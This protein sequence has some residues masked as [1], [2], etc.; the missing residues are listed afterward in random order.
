MKKLFV[1]CVFFFCNIAVAEESL[2]DLKIEKL[3]EGVYVHTSFEEAKGWSVVTKHGL[4]VLV[5]NDAYLIDTPI[6][7]KDTEKLVN[8]FVERGYKIKGSI[9]THFHGDSTAGIEW[10]NS[11]S[12][13]TYASE[14]TN[15]L[16]KKDNKVQAKHSFNGVSYSLIKNKIEVFYP[17]PGHTQDNVVV[18][19]PEKKILFGGCFVKPDGL[20]YL[21][22]ANLEAWP[23][24]AKILMSKYGKA[25][26]VV[27]SHSD[28][29]DVSLL[30]RTWEQAVKGLNESKKSS[31]PSD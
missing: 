11:Q 22:D 1:L 8:W 12:I 28:I 31:Q 17:G 5:K 2:P 13:P 18:W 26:L 7:A 15:E 20:G 30:K 19:L 10:L 27:S 21:G 24:S 3:E 23:K 9:S 6:T 25:K 14:L 4:V 16:L 29:G